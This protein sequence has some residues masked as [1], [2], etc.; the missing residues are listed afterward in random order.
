MRADLI[1]PSNLKGEIDNNEV[2]RIIGKILFV[3]L[4]KKNYESTRTHF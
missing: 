3:A 4:R 1:V 2:K